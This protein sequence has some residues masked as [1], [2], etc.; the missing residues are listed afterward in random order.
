[1]A[2]DCRKLDPMQ[3]DMQKVCPNILHEEADTDADAWGIAVVLL[4]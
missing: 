1:M 4:H 3:H 2:C